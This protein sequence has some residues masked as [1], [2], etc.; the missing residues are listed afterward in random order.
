MIYTCLIAKGNG[1]VVD[2][3]Q[4]AQ[5][6]GLA[7]RWTE[8]NKNIYAVTDKEN[9]DLVWNVLD[10]FIDDN[11]AISR[12]I[13]E[14]KDYGI[15]PPLVALAEKIKEKDPKGILV[16]LPVGCILHDIYGSLEVV[17]GAI[18]AAL[19]NPKWL[20][21]T[22]VSQCTDS[23]VLG[24]D[25]IKPGKYIGHYEGGDQ[26]FWACYKA[27]ECVSEP[28]GVVQK[29]YVESGDY[30]VGSGIF[31]WSAAGFLSAFK[32][33]QPTMYEAFQTHFNDFGDLKYIYDSFNSKLS[34][35][36]DFLQ[37]SQCEPTIIFPVNESEGIECPITTDP[38]E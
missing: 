13:S 25:Y 1:K 18:T 5:A 22:G 31:V 37:M 19:E 28:T 4:V 35:Y 36:D 24:E 3:D 8:D 2:G 27:K 9:A 29:A 26:S 32:E 30:L 21:T 16:I 23:E 20:V 38:E 33:T 12:V 10:S 17:R 7:E 15:L 14:P 11:L 6:M 34:V